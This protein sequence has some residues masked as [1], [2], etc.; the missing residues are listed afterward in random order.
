M[1]ARDLHADMSFLIACLH[2]LFPTW[3]ILR[4]KLLVLLVNFKRFAQMIV[5]KTL[6]LRLEKPANDKFYL[7]DQYLF[8]ERSIKLVYLFNVVLNVFKI[9][10]KLNQCL[11]F[12]V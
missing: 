10:H 5:G 8:R 2:F 7:A 3:W 9:N 4:V 12:K 6:H 11:K 1:V